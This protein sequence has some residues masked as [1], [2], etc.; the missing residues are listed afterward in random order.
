MVPLGMLL[1]FYSI[2]HVSFCDFRKKKKSVPFSFFSLFPAGTISCLR[3]L[4]WGA[5]CSWSECSSWLLIHTSQRL[6]FLRILLISLQNLQDNSWVS[7]KADLAPACAGELHQCRFYR[8][9]YQS[10]SQLSV[11]CNRSTSRRHSLHLL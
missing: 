8:F 1:T 4:G 2:S 11:W 5:Q 10:K 3:Q 6:I 9:Y 7:F